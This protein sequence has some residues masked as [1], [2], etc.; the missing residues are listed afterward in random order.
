MGRMSEIA[1]EKE[2]ALQSAK[3]EYIDAFSDYR[4]YMENH[5]PGHRTWRQTAE[6]ARL[7]E[8]SDVKRM[9]YDIEKSRRYI[10]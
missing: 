10:L 8:V 2:D 4:A 9:M 3:M 5:P 1:A 6:I 7:S